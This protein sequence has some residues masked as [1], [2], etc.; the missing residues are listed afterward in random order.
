MLNFLRLR[1]LFGCLGIIAQAS[2]QTP[3]VNGFAGIYPCDKVDLLSRM[4]IAQLGGQTNLAD[5]WG[6][7]DP[8]TGVEYALVGMRTGTAFVNLNNPAVPVLTGILPSHISGSNTLWRDVDVIGNYA[9]IVSETSGHGMQIF[10]LTRLRNVVTPP[11]TFTEDAHY[12]GFS[13]CHSLFADNDGFV[14]CEGTNT[15]SG[16]LHVVN[17]QNPLAPVLAGTYT[18]DGYVHENLVIDYNGPDLAHVGQDISINFHSGNPDKIT[19]VDVTNKTDMTRLNTTT[20]VGAS[21][22][23][24]GWVTPDHRYLLMNDEGDEI[25]QGHTTRTRIF[26]IS[27]L[28]SPAPLVGF[29]SGP[30]ASTDHN[31]YVNKDLVWEAN[32]SSGLRILAMDNIS[33]ATLSQAAFF[34]TYTTNNAANYD[35]AWGNYPFFNSGVVI[36]SDYANGLFI[37]RPRLSVRVR[38]LLEGPYDANIALMHDSL[39]VKGL[40]PLVE[41]YTALG[42]THV[43]GGGETTTA[44]VFL[45]SGANAIVDWVVL[46]LRN[47]ANPSVVRE[48]RCALI[49]RDGDI[50]GMDGLSAVQFTSA[51]GD[52]HVAVRHRNHLGIMTAAPVRVSVAEKSYNL[53]DGSTPLFGNAP[54]VTL[55]AAKAMWM[56]NVFRDGQL[57]YIGTDNDRDPVLLRVGGTTPNN[58]VTGYWLEDATL[59]G[60]VK[61]IGVGNDRDPMLVNVGSTIPNNVRLEQLP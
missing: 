27:D 36:V 57:K 21:I 3:C 39:R 59:D 46:E 12:A 25:N 2:A 7:T 6:W 33:T 60:V 61:Y 47:S 14:F 54:A 13:N 22:T 20:Y 8:V 9:F 48:S 10:D 38:A 50:V 28:D 35:G 51:V 43:G 58:T 37:L 5:L 41:P 30:N 56:G 29:Y 17:V 18:Q 26:N 53:A 32:Y 55:G 4:S 52:Y 15:A 11:Q 40:L 45:S 19:F 34:D 31:L 23:H 49:Q 1:S 16:G 24:Q 42:Y 44:S